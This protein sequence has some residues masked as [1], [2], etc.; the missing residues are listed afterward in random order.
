MPR[1]IS[2]VALFALAAC[3][4][5]QGTVGPAVYRAA[6]APISSQVDVTPARLAGDWH[7]RLGP[8]LG[9]VAAGDRLRLRDLRA[10]GPGR[11]ETSQGPLAGQTLWVLWLDADNRTAALGSPD[12]R[13]ALILDRAPS[14]GADRIA[15]ARDIMQ[16]QGY[17]LS[18][19]KSAG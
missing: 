10:T 2:V 6:D 7:V 1:A 5:G 12:G 18:R 13:I 4:A 16:W 3:N 11:F 9:P 19:L 15:A 17:D 14:G 8:V